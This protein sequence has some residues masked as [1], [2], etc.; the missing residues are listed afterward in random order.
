MISRVGKE[1]GARRHERQLHCQAGQIQPSVRIM[2]HRSGARNGGRLRQMHFATSRW[3]NPSGSWHVATS[4]G[5]VGKL[6]VV[7]RGCR[8]QKSGQ[9]VTPVPWRSRCVSAAMSP[10]A[11]GIVPESC[12]L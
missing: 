11:S 5:H 1:S 4:P 2:C 7:M 10:S 8:L 12:V 3:A 9:P 6:Q